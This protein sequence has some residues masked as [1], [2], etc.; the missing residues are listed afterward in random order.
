MAKLGGLQLENFVEA[1]SLP[2]KGA[3][4]WD[5]AKLKDL[6]GAKYKMLVYLGSQVVNGTLHWFIAEQTRTTNPI[7]RRVIKVA[8]LE[9]NKKFKLL[10][11]S[12]TVIAE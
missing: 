11:E 1:T 12:I 9:H 2:Q 8:I 6:V 5:G 10:D 4:A 3:T 7:I